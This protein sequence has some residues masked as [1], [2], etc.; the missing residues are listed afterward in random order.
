MQFNCRLLI[1]IL[2]LSPLSG[3]NSQGLFSSFETGAGLSATKLANKDNSVFSTFQY[4]IDFSK[5]WQGEVHLSFWE[6]EKFDFDFGLSLTKTQMEY[7]MV[8]INGLDIMAGT[9]TNV[10]GVQDNWDYDI[11]GGVYYRVIS[12][13]KNYVSF[14]PE[15]IYRKTVVRLISE[16]VL[17]DT[18]VDPVIH[19]VFSRNENNGVLILGAN[20]KY[21]YFVKPHFGLYVKGYGSIPFAEDSLK[22]FGT[23]SHFSRFHFGINF[24]VKIRIKE[25]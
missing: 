3:L 5:Q 10:K 14:G 22:F 13:E 18:I 12:N 17:S 24:G 7:S 15:L 6:S 20:I 9:Q 11:S 21:A 4:D 2:L 19:D 16:S 8:F 23:N 1:I 25:D